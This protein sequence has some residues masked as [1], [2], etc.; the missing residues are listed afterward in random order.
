MGTSLPL[1]INIR[2]SKFLPQN[3]V[4]IRFTQFAQKWHTYEIIYSQENKGI[5]EF[6]FKKIKGN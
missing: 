1:I 2:F 6:V 4:N 3:K 5:S